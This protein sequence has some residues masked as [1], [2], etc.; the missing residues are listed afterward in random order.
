M[1]PKPHEAERWMR[2][3][4]EEDGETP[5]FQVSEWLSEDQIKYLF[6]RFAAEIKKGPKA[7]PLVEEHD[8]S[9]VS[10]QE[11]SDEV[12]FENEEDEAEVDE[13]ENFFVAANEGA[14]LRDIRLQAVE[15]PDPSEHPLMVRDVNIEL[16]FVQL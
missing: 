5:K 3:A 2:E 10:T 7:K 8:E 15:D 14:L 13:D 6:S 9:S 12:F 11:E 1:I 16:F 4:T